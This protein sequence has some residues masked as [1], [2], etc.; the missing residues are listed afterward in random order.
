M[1]SGVDNGL[2]EIEKPVGAAAWMEVLFFTALFHVLQSGVDEAE[3]IG[4]EE[5]GKGLGQVGRLLGRGESR[6]LVEGESA[7][8]FA[9][10]FGDPAEEVFVVVA[11]LELSEEG[12]AFVGVIAAIEAVEGGEEHKGF[13]VVD[14]PDEAGGGGVIEPAEDAAAV[15]AVEDFPGVILSGVG[16]DDK[17][18][19]AAGA[20]D[21]VLEFVHLFGGHDVG[22]VGMGDEFVEAELFEVHGFLQR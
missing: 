11:L 1:F 3:L 17:G 15:V 19:V 9:G 8:E 21:V 10:G 18:F 12:G 6:L 5:E 4:G 20:G 22:V 14:V 16:P 2:G 7:G 13:A